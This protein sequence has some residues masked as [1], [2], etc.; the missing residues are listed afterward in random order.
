MSVSYRR[1]FP[2]M[3]FDGQVFVDAFGIKWEFDKE[4]DT[5]SKLGPAI[6]IPLARIDDCSSDDTIG[7]NGSGTECLGATNGLMSARH[8]ILLDSLPNKPGGFGIILKPGRYLTTDDGVNSIL[9]G[10][11]TLTSSSLAYECEQVIEG[12]CT[13]NKITVSLSDDFLDT[14]CVHVKGKKGPTGDKGE[15]GPRGRHGVGD[16]PRGADGLAG[17]DATTVR[18]FSGVKIVESDDIYDTAI[19]DLSLNAEEGKL[20]IVKSK[21]AVPHDDEPATK[22]SA[23][24]IFRDIEFT[25]DDLESY[26]IIAPTND[27]AGETDINVIKLP[28][29]W[30][31]NTSNPVP[32]VPM[33]LSELAQLIIDFYKAKADDVIEEWDSKIEEF[34]T[35]KD[36]EARKILADLAQEL[37]ECEFSKP[38]AFCIGIGDC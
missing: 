7:N 33:K 4:L 3:P 26:E 20:T 37:A 9:T 28:N 2:R 35:S 6:D 23:S 24:L 21:L 17:A 25:G 15:K 11:I 30:T 27:P 16:G 10:D 8:K 12:G 31:G 5:W 18:T 38:I 34:M 14:F 13:K 19:V 29:G 1:L 22:V 36:D 32:V